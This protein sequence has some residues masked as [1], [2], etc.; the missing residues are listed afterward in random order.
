MLEKKTRMRPAAELVEKTSA[1][2]ER[3]EQKRRVGRPRVDNPETMEALRNAA[4]ELFASKNYASITIKD[5]A[6]AT[7]VNA[8][9]IY[10]Y[11]GSKEGL[12]LKVVEATVDRVFGLYDDLV[13]PDLPPETVIARWLEHHIVNYRLIEKLIKISMDYASTHG[14]SSE[15][16]Q[17]I[18]TFYNTEAKILRS[19]L[20]RG[21]ESGIFREVD[22]DLMATFIS[23]FLDG[24]MVRSAIMREFEPEPT[25]RAFRAIILADLL[26]PRA[27][28]RAGATT[29][30][31]AQ[32]L[33]G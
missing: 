12:F 16:N 29:G 6:Q 27:K 31:A 2:T 9:L 4:L 8:S 17:A 30:R 3:L 33:R 26:K 24:A 22:P 14:A 20:S 10:Y 7:G 28:G 19:A 25:I 23:T 21:V 32:R 1:K 18:R 13:Q 15:I 5:L 11:F